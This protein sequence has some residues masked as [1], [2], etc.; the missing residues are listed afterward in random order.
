MS[1]LYAYIFIVYFAFEKV[2]L[3][4]STSTT[5]TKKSL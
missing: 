5:T 3:K 2:L 4:N 1:V